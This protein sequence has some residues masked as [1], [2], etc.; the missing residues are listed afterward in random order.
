MKCA[1]GYDSTKRECRSCGGTGEVAVD[2]LGNGTF[3]ADRRQICVACVA[4]SWPRGN[5]GVCQRCDQ[6]VLKLTGKSLVILLLSYSASLKD[7]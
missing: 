5:R 7:L 4:D 2:R 1:N 6:R 3:A